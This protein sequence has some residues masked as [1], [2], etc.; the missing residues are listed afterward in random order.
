MLSASIIKDE[1]NRS[2]TS[3]RTS[4]SSSILH[5][6]LSSETFYLTSIPQ[7]VCAPQ[8]A[9][10]HVLG[11]SYFV[12]VELRLLPRQFFFGVIHLHANQEKLDFMDQRLL[13]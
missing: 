10:R 2:V 13:A 7:D 8:D 5:Y 9:Q 1:T 11:M 3:V 4:R 12:M 6:G